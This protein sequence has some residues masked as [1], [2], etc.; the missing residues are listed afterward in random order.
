MSLASCRVRHW[1]CLGVAASRTDFREERVKVRVNDK[2]EDRVGAEGVD[3]DGDRKV[4]SSTM[5]SMN[6]RKEKANARK[7]SDG[8]RG[9]RSDD[10]ARDGLVRRPQ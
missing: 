9:T 7:R 4:A 6:E 2:G 8:S 3:K 10:R 5:R 1:P